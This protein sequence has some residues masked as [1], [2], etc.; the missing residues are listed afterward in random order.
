MA[1]KRLRTL[2]GALFAFVVLGALMAPVAMAD[3]ETCPKDPASATYSGKIDTA[4]DPTS[5][6]A[7]APAGWL[8]Y[9]YCVKGGSDASGGGPEIVTVDPPQSSITFSHSTNPT[10]SHYSVWYMQPE[11]EP[12]T[13]EVCALNED[14]SYT[15]VDGLTSEEYTDALENGGVDPDEEGACPEDEEETPPP[16]DEV[17]PDRIDKP[18]DDEVLPDRVDRPAVAGEALPFTG[19]DPTPFLALASLL[20]ASGASALVISRSKK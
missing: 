5:V 8:I 2:A 3:D 11:P 4:G 7:T 20:A 10:V 6:T 16:D 17:L 13:F 9:Q 15:L 18:A 19:I 1:S 14:G 12:E